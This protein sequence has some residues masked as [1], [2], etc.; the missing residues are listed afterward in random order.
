MT[1]VLFNLF[2]SPAKAFQKLK[3]KPLILFTYLFVVLVMIVYFTAFRQMVPYEKRI[4]A[5]IDLQTYKG[6]DIP[7]DIKE[8][9]LNNKENIYIII[10]SYISLPLLTFV[11]FF[12]IGLFI[13]FLSYFISGKSIT[14]RESLCISFNG[15]F[16]PVVTFLVI[17]TVMMIFSPDSIDP[18]RPDRTF[19][20]NLALFVDSSLNP[21]LANL[22]ATVDLFLIWRTILILI[23]IRVMSGDVM[24]RKK[25][26]IFLGAAI[27]FVFALIQFLSSLIVT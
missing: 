14:I 2:F 5:A 23:G 6:M 24:K 19:Q 10:F 15:G 16:P 3:E 25:N 1:K 11:I 4:Q 12:L 20:A 8:E 18:L 26:N 9:M 27:Y 21:L 13:Q 17:T 7:D 22:A